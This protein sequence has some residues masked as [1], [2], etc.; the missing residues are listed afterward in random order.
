MIPVYK[1]WDKAVADIDCAPDGTTQLHLCAVCT[2]CQLQYRLI[3]CEQYCIIICEQYRLI[4]CEY[5][6]II[7]DSIADAMNPTCPPKYARVYVTEQA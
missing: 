6:L 5:R 2:W 1:L 7:C 3:I 4:I